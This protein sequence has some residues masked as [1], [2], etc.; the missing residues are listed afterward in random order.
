MLP[1]IDQNNSI[2]G[3]WYR[4]LKNSELMRDTKNTRLLFFIFFVLFVGLITISEQ[5]SIEIDL[6]F[7]FCFIENNGSM[8][9]HKTGTRAE[10]NTS[11]LNEIGD[12]HR[13]L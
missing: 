2:G 13:E 4:G 5:I 12:S 6:S 10:E 3:W 7:Q 1:H 11:D 8:N 9:D